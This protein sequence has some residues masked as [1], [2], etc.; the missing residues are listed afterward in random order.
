ML[1][2]GNSKGWFERVILKGDSKGRFWRV[3]R[4]I[5]TGLKGNSKGF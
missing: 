2:K 4:V 3:L 5:L 1:L